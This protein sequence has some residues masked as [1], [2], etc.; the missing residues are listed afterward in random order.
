MVG[1]GD[2]YFNGTGEVFVGCRLRLDEGAVRGT[3]R[4]T[5][6]GNEVPRTIC[7]TN[8]IQPVSAGEHVVALDFDTV[9]QSG[10]VESASLD[11]IFIPFAG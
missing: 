8:G 9:A 10:G 6:V 5:F 3:H 1:S 2:I 7:A 4:S 11:V